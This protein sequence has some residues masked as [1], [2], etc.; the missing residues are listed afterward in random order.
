MNQKN[1]LASFEYIKLFI[2]SF[3]AAVPDIKQST[4]FCDEYELPKQAGK[5]WFNSRLI[6]SCQ[7]CTG[8]KFGIIE[9]H[10]DFHANFSENILKHVAIL[11][12][13]IQQQ[14]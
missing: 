8:A 4:I 9:M 1:P 12:Q 3:A 6:E 5:Y 14:R 13:N 11:K 7:T 2:F 10:H